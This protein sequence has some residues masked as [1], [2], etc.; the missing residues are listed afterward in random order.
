MNLPNSQWI[1]AVNTVSIINVPDQ[2]IFIG[3][4]HDIVVELGGIAT[5]T[6]GTKSIRIEA[7][8]L[9][10]LQDITVRTIRSNTA[11]PIIAGSIPT[12]S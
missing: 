5:M 3:M 1:E 4:L 6:V 8:R 12:T 11:D 2:G 10:N 7:A 9:N